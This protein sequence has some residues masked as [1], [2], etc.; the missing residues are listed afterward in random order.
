MNYGKITKEYLVLN[1]TKRK[2]YCIIKTNLK[3]YGLYNMNKNK[4][5]LIIDSV[6]IGMISNKNEAQELSGG[7]DVVFINEKSPNNETVGYFVKSESKDF[8]NTELSKTLNQLVSKNSSFKDTETRNNGE[9]DFNEMSV[10]TLKEILLEAY[11]I[12]IEK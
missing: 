12:G 7:F 9:D 2:Y 11:S 6:V 5:P 8:L 10:W 1:F 3:L 4:I